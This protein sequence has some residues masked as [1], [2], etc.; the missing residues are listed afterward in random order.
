MESEH[1]ILCFSILSGSSR[2]HRAEG[3]CEW[4]CCALIGSSRHMSVYKEAGWAGLNH[5]LGHIC[6]WKTELLLTVQPHPSPLSRICFF[7]S[8][9]E[10]F[11]LYSSLIWGEWLFNKLLCD[12]CQDR[13]TSMCFFFFFFL[14]GIPSIPGV[15]RRE[16]KTWWVLF[17]YVFFKCFLCN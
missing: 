11:L 7:L 9:S 15:H 5:S 16:G 3:S 4:A 17:P 2:T 1:F 6:L 14:A 12:A 10:G 8:S 13:L